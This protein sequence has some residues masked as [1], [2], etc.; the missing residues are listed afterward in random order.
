VKKKPPARRYGPEPTG[1]K[2]RSIKLT[3]EEWKALATIAKR[4]HLGDERGGRTA[5]VQWLIKVYAEGSL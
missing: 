1:A 4:E 5:A 2:M 3:D